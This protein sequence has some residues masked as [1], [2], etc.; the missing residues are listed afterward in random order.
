MPELTPSLNYFLIK[1][2]HVDAKLAK[3]LQH[4]KYTKFVH[5][6][7]FLKDQHLQNL[8]PLLSFARNPIYIS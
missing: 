2:N 6:F 7:F 4:K 8:A 3:S 5:S 1:N